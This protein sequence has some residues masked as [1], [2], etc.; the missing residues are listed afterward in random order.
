MHVMSHVSKSAG[1]KRP[2]MHEFLHNSLAHVIS[3]RQKCKVLSCS[4]VRQASLHLA[5]LVQLLVEELYVSA[6]IIPPTY[7]CIS[8]PS[9]DATHLFCPSE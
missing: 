2:V 4:I 1:K 5:V 6:V 9:L 8:K 3:R 7:G